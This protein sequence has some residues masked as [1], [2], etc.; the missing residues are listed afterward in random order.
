MQ[1]SL[2]NKSGLGCTDGEVLERLWSYTS[3]GHFSR[4]TNEMRP[5]DCIDVLTDELLYYGR[6]AAS[7]LSESCSYLQW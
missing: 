5:A 4:M 6:Q 3:C 1:Q 2:H 7:N